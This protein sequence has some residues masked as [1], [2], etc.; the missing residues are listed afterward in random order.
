M[1][2]VDLKAQ[3]KVLKKKIDENI[4]KVLNNADYIGGQEVKELEQKLA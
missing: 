4:Q 3:Y 2:F 1:E